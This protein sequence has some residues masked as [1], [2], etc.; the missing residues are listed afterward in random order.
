MS[1]NANLRAVRT[2]ALASLLA[3]AP[4]LALD[5]DDYAQITSRW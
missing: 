1:S 2:L 3:P 5:A 4:V